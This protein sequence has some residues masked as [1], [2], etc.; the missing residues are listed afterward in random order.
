[1]KHLTIILLTLSLTGCAAWK[2]S[3][4]DVAKLVDGACAIATIADNQMYKGKPASYWCAI[5]GVAAEAAASIQE[6]VEK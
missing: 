2:P 4:R 5:V 3:L 1:M 6:A